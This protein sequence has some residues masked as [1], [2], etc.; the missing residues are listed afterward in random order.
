MAMV[1]VFSTFAIAA[2]ATTA[3]TTDIVLMTLTRTES[4]AAATNNQFDADG[5]LFAAQAHLTAW[6]NNEQIAIG[7]DGRVRAPIV[8]NNDAVNNNTVGGNGW[9]SVGPAEIDEGITVDTATAFQLR[10]ETTAHENIRFTARQRSTGSG[11][12]FFALAYSLG[13]ATGPF[14]PIAD[15]I[16]A[17]VQSPQGF[18]DNAYT[19]FDFAG[20]N[21]FTNVALPTTLA[22]QSVVYLRVYMINSTLGDRANGNTSI[23]DI[24]VIGDVMDLASAADRAPLVAAVA[25]AQQREQANYSA[26]SWAV[27]AAALDDAAAV[28]ANPNATVGEVNAALAALIQAQGNLLPG[29]PDTG[30]WGFPS[31]HIFAD[32]HPFHMPR[33]EWH[34]GRVTVPGWFEDVEVGLRG[35]GHS[36]WYHHRSEEKRP[37]RLRFDNPNRALFSDN[38]HRD[39]ILLANHHDRSLLRTYAA[40]DFATRMGARMQYVPMAQNLHLYINGEYHGVYILTDERDVGPDRMN[41]T[42]NEDPALSEFFIEY[43]LRSFTSGDIEND[44]FVVVNGR[45]YDIRFPTS[46]SQRRAHA[47]HLQGLIYGVSEAIRYACWC[48]LE[49]YI[50][51]DSFVDFFLINEFM[52]NLSMHYSSTFMNFTVQ[53]DGRQVLA[54]GPIWDFDHGYFGGARSSVLQRHGLLDGRRTQNYWFVTLMQRPQFRQLV[55]ERWTQLMDD[56]VQ[57]ATIARVRHMAEYYNADFQRNHDAFGWRTRHERSANEL[58]DWMQRRT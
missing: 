31:I 44:H 17:N 4:T 3:D 37:L 35:R 28:L 11:P 34:L 49:T 6:N 23:N 9:R 1:L 58:L 25:A 39:W 46:G 22:N 30:N 40:F 24:V 50:C 21:T 29:V 36:T 16:T 15:T 54:M 7:Y 10:F 52:H 13:G 45:P 20:A 51:V 38:A 27:F 57:H 42:F 19:D 5:G 41:L 12:Q 32:N 43:C 55:A 18:R 47:E 33:A 8:I 26:T 56:G 53:E 14:T 2:A 48:I